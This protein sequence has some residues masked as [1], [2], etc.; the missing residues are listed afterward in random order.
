MAGHTE[1]HPP[2]QQT[3]KPPQNASL[4]SG[5]NLQANAFSPV[6]TTTMCTD[7]TM[8]VLL[9]TARTHVYRPTSPQSTMKIRVL[10]D[11]GSQRSYVTDR[12]KEALS[13]P[14]EK[15]QKMLIK[16]FGS[17]QEAKR[18]CDVV[19]IGLRTVGEAD[20][21]MPFFSVPLICQPLSHQPITFCK[22]TYDHLAPLNLADFQEGPTEL[23]IDMLIG[24]DHYWK[25][26]T[27]EIVRGDSGPTAIC[28]RLGWVLSGPTHCPDQRTS[29]VNVITTHTL[30]IDSQEA[31]SQT[32]EG[33][34]VTL[35]QFWDLESLGIKGND[36][37]T[38]ENFDESII[39]KNGRYQVCLL[40][41]ETHPTLPDN[42]QLSKK[43]LIRLLHSLKQRPSILRDYDATI[44]DQ[45]SNGIVEQ[46]DDSDH[47]ITGET[48]YI[49]HHAVIRQ[50][51][52]TTKLRVVYNASAKE[53]GPSLNDCLYA[54]PKLGQN[55]MDIILRFRVHKALAADIEKAFLMVSMAERDR[56]VLRFLWVDDVTRD[57]PEII[58]YR[59]TQVVFG[60]S[61]S[62][63]LLNATIRH[64]LKK[65]SSVL[66]ETVRRISR[67]IYV[68]DI[69]YGPDTEDLAYKL[70]LEFKSLLKEGGFNLRKFVT[71]S[72]N[73][74]RKIE[75]HEGQL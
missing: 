37:S 3:Q 22:A 11:G 46:V 29:A 24:S 32:D 55:I 33:L 19:R 49:P 47:S 28:T 52:Q 2:A 31:Q 13:L 67:S 65:Y 61:S 10:M 45:F 68:D 7:S 21:E 70:Y 74:Q 6:T 64:H 18:V 51:K 71:N 12:V 66:P 34:D 60:V 43:R 26:V 9:Q 30:K 57:D 72:T 42:Y 54:G 69:A 50:D 40:W 59:F 44:K 56:Y 62:P 35:Q 25:I 8:A 58:A 20:L 15:Q 41:K 48:H 14:T 75:Q 38:L 27:G 73:L 4:P 1:R 17:E 39:F 23:D 53:D 16:M 36:G 5:L 63:F